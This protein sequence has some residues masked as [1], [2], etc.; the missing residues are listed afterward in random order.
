M[1]MAQPTQEE[2]RTI[3]YQQSLGEAGIA[4]HR[5]VSNAE[6]LVADPMVQAQKLVV[7]REHDLSGHVRIAASGLSMSRTPLQ[8]GRPAPKPGS[9]APG[10]LAEI[11]L[12]Q[13]LPR[14]IREKIVVM[15][16]ITGDW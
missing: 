4:S 11:G 13:E 6:E 10:I 8:V 2:W 7:T 12:A 9:D 15:D 3:R 5:V 14:L 1:S 16:G